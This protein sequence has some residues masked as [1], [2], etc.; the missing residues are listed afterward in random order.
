MGQW[1][2]V[3]DCSSLN[4]GQLLSAVVVGQVLLAGVC[5]LVT[6]SQRLLVSSCRSVFLNQ[7]LLVNDSGPVFVSQ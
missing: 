7:W 2:L 1:L 3:N 4:I 6:I 5:V